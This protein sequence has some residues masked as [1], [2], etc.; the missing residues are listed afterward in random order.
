MITGDNPLTACHV[1]KEL[2]ITKLPVMILEGEEEGE[3]ERWVW[4]SVKGDGSVTF[5]PNKERINDLVQ[6][7]ELCV[8]GKVMSMHTLYTIQV[9]HVH[10]YVYVYYL[11]NPFIFLGYSV[12]DVFRW[13]EVT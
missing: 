7:N 4:Q 10:V 12:F 5:D 6:T 1:A 3:G 13:S 11:F 2:K 8:T 9:V